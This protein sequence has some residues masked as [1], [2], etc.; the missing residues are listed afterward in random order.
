MQGIIAWIL[1]LLAW[2]SA[3]VA[4]ICTLTAGFAAFA[5]VAILVMFPMEAAR[6][7][8]AY[9]T[10]SQYARSLAA[11]HRVMRPAR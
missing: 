1:N 5:A 11:R 9:A 10:V 4:W 3:L 8:G 7:R 6:N 2:I